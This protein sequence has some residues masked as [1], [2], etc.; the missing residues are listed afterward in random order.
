[1]AT[2]D[3]QRQFEQIVER[4]TADYPSLQRV[5]R[6]WPRPVLITVLTVGGIGWGLLSVAMVAWGAAG[7]ALTFGVVALAAAALYV[8][9]YRRRR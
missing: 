2:E 6:L 7:V 3:R 4:L 9:G 5:P 1:M 8:D